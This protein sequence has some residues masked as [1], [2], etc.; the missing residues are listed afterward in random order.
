MTGHYTLIIAA[1]LCVLLHGTVHIEF[2]HTLKPCSCGLSGRE[3]PHSS[4]F[5]FLVAWCVVRTP[6]TLAGR[7]LSRCAAKVGFYSYSIYLWHTIVVAAF[8]YHPAKSA[9]KFWI[10]IATTIITGI[11]MAQLI[12]LPYLTLRDKLFPPSQTARPPAVSP[13]EVP[14]FS[15]V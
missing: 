10:F 11:A 8:E 6:K 4:K 14:Y 13:T 1:L 15:A 5:S 7:I 12:E 9:A 2:T 3:Q